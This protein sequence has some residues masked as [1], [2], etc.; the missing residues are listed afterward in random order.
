M[1]FSRCSTARVAAAL[2][3]QQASSADWST[4]LTSLGLAPDAN[5]SLHSSATDVLPGS[6]SPSGRRNSSPATATL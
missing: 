6:K 2:F 1:S 4:S 5:S 3:L